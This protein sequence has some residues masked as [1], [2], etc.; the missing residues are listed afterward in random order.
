MPGPDRP[1]ATDPILAERERLTH[2]ADLA[3]TDPHLEQFPGRDR[4]VDP[5]SVKPRPVEPPPLEVDPLEQ[6]IA[7]LAAIYGEGAVW[8]AAEAVLSI[9]PAAP[10]PPLDE[11]ILPPLGFDPNA[12]P[13][14]TDATGWAFA[15]GRLV[16]AIETHG[17][18]ELDEAL[19]VVRPVIDALLPE[20]V[21]TGP[22]RARLLEPPAEDDA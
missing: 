3:A 2:L 11:P 17:T 9:L 13:P 18:P 19:D 6:A 12:R 4:P 22:P 8:D 1:A 20:G 16:E 15:T 10:G 5:E 14:A 21:T 7:D